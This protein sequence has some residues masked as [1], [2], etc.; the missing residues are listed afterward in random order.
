MDAFGRTIV[1]NAANRW[2][3]MWMADQQLATSLAEFM[4]V[5]YVDPVQSAATRFR[6]RGWSSVRRTR[7]RLTLLGPRLARLEP[8]GLPGISHRG[9]TNINARLSAVQVRAALKRLAADPFA[10]I[11]AN[12]LAPISGGVG[13]SRTVYWAQD[14]FEAL[15]GLVGGA[16]ESYAR[17]DAR[18][19]ASADVIIAANPR[20]AAALRSRG[21]YAHLVPFGCNAEHFSR[22]ATENVPS[23]VSLGRPFAVFVGHLG[24]R[25]DLTILEG[26]ASEGLRLLLVGPLHPRAD[27]S[28]FEA[29]A[30]LP[31][32]QWV[33]PRPFES[34]PSYLAGAE[35]ALVPYMRSPFNMAS[36]P[37]KT[38]EYLAAGLP[39]VSTPLPGVEWI[40][41]ED[42][43]IA[44]DPDRFVEEVGR[45]LSLGRDAAGDLRRRK[46]AQDHS[47]DRRAEAVASVL[48]IGLK[49]TGVSD[50][51]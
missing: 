20:V 46:L 42:V 25:I 15:A 30:T 43:H 47:W 41:S 32:V 11:E 29:L 10:S 24:E 45:L 28:R 31:G 38:L 3:D 13:E 12:V 16:A 6:D 8:E 14:D 21:R 48:G 44:S 5:L 1:L 22:S 7:T 34:L 37:L 26:L 35:V 2:D 50:G 19:A 27:R 17:G 39:V 18:L 9:I 33:G 51:C 4:P 23:D 40:G 36:F 49:R